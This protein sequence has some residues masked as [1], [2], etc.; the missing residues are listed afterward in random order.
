MT[1][2]LLDP[3]SELDRVPINER[4]GWRSY[5]RLDHG[6]YLYAGRFWT[7]KV[8]AREAGRRGYIEP[9]ILDAVQMQEAGFP[10]SFQEFV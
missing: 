2:Q 6:G 8:A 7:R 3:S 10:K 4:G 9:A 5:R 1:A